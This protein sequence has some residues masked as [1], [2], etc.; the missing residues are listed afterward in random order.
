[1]KL[2]PALF[3]LLNLKEMLSEEL[4]EVLVQLAE[5][6]LAAFLAAVFN[7]QYQNTVFGV[8]NT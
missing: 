6:L 5:K 8:E 4:K 7:L 2:I 3:I 1:M